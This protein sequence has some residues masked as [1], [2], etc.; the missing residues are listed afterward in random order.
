MS[1]EKATRSWA[2]LVVGGLLKTIAFAIM[3]AIPLLGVWSASSLAA[4]SNGP[5]ALAIAC[6]ALAW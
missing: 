1:E 5:I 6:G 4:Y 2:G 3:I